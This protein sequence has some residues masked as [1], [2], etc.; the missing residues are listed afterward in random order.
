MWTEDPPTLDPYLNVTFRSQEFAAFFYSRLLMSKKGR[1][2]A[3][4]A[5]VMEG[6]LADSCKVSDDGLTYTFNLRPNAKWQNLPPV[7]GRPVTAQDVVWSF[8]AVHENF[9]SEVGIRSSRKRHRAGRKDR[10]VSPERYIR[11]LRDAHRLADP[12]DHAA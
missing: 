1:G 5:Y 9:T 11:A 7:N 6:D 2:I 10:R 8:R 3:A 4:Q 12:M